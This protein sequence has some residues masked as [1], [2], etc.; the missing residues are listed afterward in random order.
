MVLARRGTPTVLIEPRAQYPNCFKAEKLEPD[1]WAILQKFELLDV[2]APVCADIHQ[3]Q[4]ASAGHLYGEINLRQFGFLYHNLVNRI[5][6]QLP[7]TLDIRHSKVVDISSHIQDFTNIR[8]CM[9]LRIYWKHSNRAKQKFRELSLKGLSHVLGE[10]SCSCLLSIV[11]VFY[12]LACIIYTC[13]YHMTD[14]RTK[15]PMGGASSK[16]TYRESDKNM[17]ENTIW[18]KSRKYNMG[19]KQKI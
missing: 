5:R 16:T 6:S 1:Q 13:L 7:S 12:A 8:L 18:A 9:K 2:V 10:D 4:L 19:Q 11:D 17:A 3:V 14:L 15:P